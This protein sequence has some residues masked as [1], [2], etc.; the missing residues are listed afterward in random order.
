MEMYTLILAARF[1]CDHSCRNLHGLINSNFR[2][3]PELVINFRS[4]FVHTLTFQEFKQD[5]Y[6]Y[7]YTN[8]VSVKQLE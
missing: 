5:I 8:Y 1:F 6:K 3:K 7:S 4:V 2:G